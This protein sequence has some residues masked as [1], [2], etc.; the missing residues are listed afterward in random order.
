MYKAQVNGKAFEI[1]HD[2]ESWVVNGSPLDW[3]L[4]SLGNGHYHI[5]FQK[6]GYRAEVVKQTV[7]RKQWSLKSTE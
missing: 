3:D 6:K 5:L 2:K 1:V 7:N 4:T